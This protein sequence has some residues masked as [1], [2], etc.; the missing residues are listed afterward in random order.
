MALQRQS[1]AGRRAGGA[2]KL[3]IAGLK[4]VASDNTTIEEGKWKLLAESVQAIQT[5]TPVATT[6]QSL[7]SMVTDMASPEQC[8]K[9]IPRLHKL[10]ESYLASKAAELKALPDTGSEGFLTHIDRLWLEHCAQMV[11]VRSIFVVV[12]RANIKYHKGSMPIWDASL[13]MF[14]KVL[15]TETRLTDKLVACLLE[16]IK[17]DRKGESTRQDTVRSLIAMMVALKLYPAFEAPFLKAS[18]QFYDQESLDKLQTV[19]IAQY[20]EYASRRLSQESHRCKACMQ[21]QTLRPLMA[22][23]EGCLLKQHMTTILEE[24]FQDLMDRDDIDHIKLLYTLCQRVHC[25]EQLQEA[26]KEHVVAHGKSLVTN[27]EKDKTMVEDLLAYQSRLLD[28]LKQSFGDEAGFLYAHKVAFEKFINKRANKPAEMIARFVDAK[29]RTGYKECPEEELDALLDRVLVLFRYTSGK[30]VFEAYYKNHLARRL[31]HNKSASSDLERTMLAKL[32]QE[33]GAAFTSNLEGMFKDVSIAQELN[34]SYQQHLQAK[35]ME[36]SIDLSVQVLTQSHWPS[37]APLPMTLPQEMTAIQEQFKTFYCTKHQS[38]VLKWQN[39]Q[40]HCVVKAKFPKGTKDLQMALSQTVIMLAF[41]DHTS[42]SFKQL[43]E[44][45]SLEDTEL[46]RS[47]LSMSLGKTRVLTK[48]I[49]AKS[50]T[51][52]DR[53]AVNE[54]FSDKHKRVKINQ[55]QLKETAAETT[56]T[57]DRIFQDRIYAVD[58]AIVR[59][60]KTRKT[61]K[62]SLLMST[63]L[64]ELKFPFKPSDIKKRIESLIDRDYL[65]RAENDSQTYNYLA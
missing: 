29:L 35:G 49:K 34:A 16:E 17:A 31:L 15:L 55:I 58:A 26:Y 22:A 8:A 7:R 1:F 64:E 54:K 37:Y 24:K 65:A 61:L 48:S 43:Q 3:T 23:L 47:L 28:I 14:R 9:L 52:D 41:N 60:M 20:L 5:K 10:L 30:D 40:G 21:E 32:K 53:F 44:L 46:T 25:V 63:L 39:S 12:D 2:K 11:L 45:T 18:H 38:R 50:I 27:P 42:L 56:A 19:E 57:N 6:L 36:P 62:H 33:C 51:D 13:I 59:I 4:R